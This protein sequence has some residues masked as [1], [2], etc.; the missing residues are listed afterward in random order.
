[1]PLTTDI[2]ERI[3][4]SYSIEAEVR[5]RP[6][7]VRLAARQNRTTPLVDGLRKKLDAALAGCRESAT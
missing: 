2:L 1:M 7:D 6:P 3:G 4:V 5:G